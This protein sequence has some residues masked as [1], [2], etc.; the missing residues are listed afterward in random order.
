MNRLPRT[1][2]WS[3][4][5]ARETRKLMVKARAK[6]I[7]IYV[8]TTVILFTL[9]QKFSAR[10]TKIRFLYSFVFFFV[11]YISSSLTLYTAT[12]S[13]RQTLRNYKNKTWLK[14]KI[15]YRNKHFILFDCI[16]GWSQRHN[17]WDDYVILVVNV[18]LIKCVN[19]HHFSTR[20]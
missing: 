6:K 15:L 2:L 11:F 12:D 14:K 20:N 9:F 17:L 5:A 4:W 19:I 8:L 18:I 13:G 3:T 7:N 1:F 10:T 16:A